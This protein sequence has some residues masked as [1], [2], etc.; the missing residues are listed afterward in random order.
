MSSDIKSLSL[1]IWSVELDKV[2]ILFWNA[3]QL[4]VFIQCA[5]TFTHGGNK[6]SKTFVTYKH[7]Y[8]YYTVT[9]IKHTYMYIQIYVCLFSC[10]NS[11]DK[12][13]KWPLAVFQWAEYVA[14]T[15]NPM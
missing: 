11:P 10:I 4:I 13:M 12:K 5:C 14:I 1:C 3:R 15:V 2:T 6:G 7:I 9:A 8:I